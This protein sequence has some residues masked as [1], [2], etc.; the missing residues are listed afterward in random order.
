MVLLVCLFI[1]CVAVLNVFVGAEACCTV[2]SHQTNQ[3]MFEIIQLSV[4]NNG[5]RGQPP[6]LHPFV[7]H[8][9]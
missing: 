1:F 2:V 7:G 6:R 9:V 5:C 3:Q 4:Q 8:E